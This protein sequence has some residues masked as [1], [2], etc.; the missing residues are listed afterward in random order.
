MEWDKNRARIRLKLNETKMDDTKMK[1]D[2]NE[3]R[4]KWNQTKMEWT[5]RYLYEI[6]FSQSLPQSCVPS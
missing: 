1:W 3:I 6:C 5:F 4:L 2:Q